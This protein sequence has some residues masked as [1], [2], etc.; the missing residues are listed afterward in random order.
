M[1]LAAVVAVFGQSIPKVSSVV[2]SSDGGVGVAL[3]DY[4]TVYGAGLADATYQATAVPL[5]IKLGSTEV[6]VCQYATQ[7]LHDEGCLSLALLYASSGQVNFYLP[8]AIPGPYLTVR[9]NGVVDSNNGTVPA[10]IGLASAPSI[11]SEGYDCF[12]GPRYQDFGKNC[13][14]SW[15]QPPT[16]AANRGAVTDLNGVLLSSS[17]RARLN[18][19]ITIWATGLGATGK[20][21]GYSVWMYNIPVYGYSGDTYAPVNALYVG[22]SVTFPGLY[23]INLQVPASLATGNSS[24]Y[25][26]PFPCGSYNWEISFGLG[27]NL[28]QVPIVVS[29]GDVPCAP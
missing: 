6:Y 12:T 24:G 15:T 5:P 26:P 10:S 17:N 20:G 18:Q 2:R 29:P 4:G 3:D 16:Y 25:P 21:S 27:T 13:G 9:V 22:E 14:L 19:Y 1:L 7:G 23:Q 8:K 11:I 28:V